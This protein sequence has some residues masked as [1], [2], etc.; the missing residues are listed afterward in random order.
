MAQWLGLQR[1]LDLFGENKIK[2]EE[3]NWYIDN[4]AVNASA[5]E[6]NKLDGATVTVD[7]LNELDDVV[8]SVRST[9]TVAAEAGNSIAVTVQ[10][11]DASDTN[12]ARVCDVECHLSSSATT[13]AIAADDAI[14]VTAST[15]SLITEHVDDLYFYCVTDSAGKL[16]LDVAAAGDT[17]A[18]YLWV[19]FPGR[20]YKVSAAIDLA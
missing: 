6:L 1:V 7:E 9:V 5:A 12:M 2:L 8:S 19:R 18:K 10:L 3:S 4:T 15:G 16:V 17:T 20:A 13:G 14:T 11:K